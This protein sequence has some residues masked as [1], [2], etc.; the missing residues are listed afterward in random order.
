M[1]LKIELVQI[2]VLSCLTIFAQGAYAQTDY[3]VEPRKNYVPL[4]EFQ[5]SYILAD[6]TNQ[7]KKCD[8]FKRGET[9]EVH[10]DSTEEKWDSHDKSGPTF[11]ILWLTGRLRTHLK[12]ASPQKGKE[13]VSGVRVDKSS[14]NALFSGYFAPREI[15]SFNMAKR[16]V[17]SHQYFGEYQ[18]YQGELIERSEDGQT[19]TMYGIYS[20]GIP[21]LQWTGAVSYPSQILKYFANEVCVL[22]KI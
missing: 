3:R 20:S 19:L 6:D 7:R 14:S 18:I 10:L 2:V 21:K 9:V 13:D 8:R 12:L 4:T 1:K 17:I 11:Q 22:R 5:G 15:Y 16:W